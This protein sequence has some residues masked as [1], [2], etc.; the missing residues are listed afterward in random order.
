MVIE[1]GYGAT[2]EWVLSKIIF[3]HTKIDLYNLY[4]KLFS[5]I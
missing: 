4:C 1:I 3:T 2:F 5:K